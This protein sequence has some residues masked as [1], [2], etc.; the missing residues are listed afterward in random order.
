MNFTIK[1]ILRFDK[2][3]SCI[4]NYKHPPTKYTSLSSFHPVQAIDLFLFA[5]PKI[6]LVHQIMKLM[7]T[8]HF[9]FFI[10]CQFL[11]TF[12]LPLCMTTLTDC[13]ATTFSIS[14]HCPLA[15]ENTIGS[16]KGDCFLQSKLHW[17]TNI[18]WYNLIILKTWTKI[19]LKLSFSQRLFLDKVLTDAH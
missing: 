15:H 10:R 14:P 2:A 5:P 6:I 16:L 8:S 12:W 4:S 17:P 18:L 9:P 1:G 11:M 3:L 7:M 13:I 19:L